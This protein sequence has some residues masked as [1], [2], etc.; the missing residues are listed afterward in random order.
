MAPEGASSTFQVTVTDSEGLQST[1]SCVVKIKAADLPDDDEPP[2]GE[3]QEKLQAVRENLLAVAK[4]REYSRKV[5][6][7]FRY[8]ARSLYIAEELFEKKKKEYSS[9]AVGKAIYLIKTAARM[10][11]RNSELQTMYEEFIQDLEKL[12]A[13][14]K[15]A[16]NNHD[17]DDDGD[18]D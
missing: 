6:R 15:G 8:S 11:Q 7:M 16:V 13:A 3:I 10:D 17:D 9:K 4:D 1:D 14:I 18:D 2:S 5:R 12:K